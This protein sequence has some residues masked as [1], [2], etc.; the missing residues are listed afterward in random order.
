MEKAEMVLFG[1][2]VGMIVFNIILNAIKKPNRLYVILSS[3]IELVIVSVMLTLNVISGN[4]MWIAWAIWVAWDV[5]VLT[6]K[7][8][9]DEQT[10]QGLKGMVNFQQMI[11]VNQQLDINNSNKANTEH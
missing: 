6:R 1:V 11:I 5:A 4:V 3:V 7:I 10:I 2:L 8:M 9:K